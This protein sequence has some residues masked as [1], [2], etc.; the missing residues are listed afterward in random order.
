MGRPTAPLIPP[1]VSSYHGHPRLRTNLVRKLLL[2]L[3]CRVQLLEAIAGG[4]FTSPAAGKF[5]LSKGQ[6]ELL[7]T[8]RIACFACIVVWA[9][10]SDIMPS[11]WL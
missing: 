7:K 4:G 3:N 5:A 8:V 10:A 1:F 9:R 2:G 6:L 11:L